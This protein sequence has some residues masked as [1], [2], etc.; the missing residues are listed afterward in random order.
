MA[1][2]E[3]SHQKIHCLLVS[4]WSGTETPICIS[5][6]VQTQGWKCPLQKLGDKRIKLISAEEGV[7]VGGEVVGEG[8]SMSLNMAQNLY[9]LKDEFKHDIFTV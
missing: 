1:H 7:G 2:N 5:G 4:F 6:H 8:Y 3:P 9:L